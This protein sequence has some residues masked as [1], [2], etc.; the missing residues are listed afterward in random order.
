MSWRDLMPRRRAAGGVA[1]LP[2]LTFAELQANG[3]LTAAIRARCQA[4]ALGDHTVLCRIL[5]RY[6]LLLDSR[7]HVLA[8]HLMLDGCVE[9]W[10]ARYI[11][12]RLRPGQVAWDVGAKA[13]HLTL[14]M[15]EA[16][17]PAGRVIGFEPNPRLAALAARSLALNGL[18]DRAEMRRLAVTARSRGTVRLRTRL[19]DPHGARLI[20][21]EAPA[22]EDD[23]TLDVAVATMRLDDVEPAQV[24]LVR[25]DGPETAEAAWAGMGGV[26]DRNPDLTLVLRFNTAGCREPSRLAAELAERFPLREL[27]EDGRVG[28]V[29][30]NELLD[31]RG[32]TTLILARGPV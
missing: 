27:G 14:P 22:A 5:G 12:R 15:A 1:G 18:A 29:E 10:T 7:D 21:P 16:V 4:V 32:D 17:G 3:P 9:P 6:K 30:G 23:D 31:R 24:H 2:L 8:P 26:L 25:M 11:A 13:G 28:P 20:D 19:S